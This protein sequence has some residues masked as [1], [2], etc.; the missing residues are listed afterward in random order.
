MLTGLSLIHGC[1]FGLKLKHKNIMKVNVIFSRSYEIDV[2]EHTEAEEI[3][4]IA[5][6]MAMQAFQDDDEIGATAPNEDNYSSKIIPCNRIEY[7]V[8]KKD[9]ADAGIKDQI[10][11]YEM[12][13]IDM[14]DL[15]HGIA[16]I[17]LHNGL[18]LNAAEAQYVEN[19]SKT[20]S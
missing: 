17:M 7:A 4:T 15:V 14:Y 11:N 20:N 2:P 9:S 18:Y 12:G 13:L 19:E 6:Q 10:Q 3:E 8:K 16:S 1:I 5:K